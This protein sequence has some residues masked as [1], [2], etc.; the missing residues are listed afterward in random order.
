[1]LNPIHLRTL[2]AVVRTGSFAAAAKELGYT[3]SAI[4]QQIASLEHDVGLP[5]FERRARSVDPTPAAAFLTDR[6]VEVLALLDDLQNAVG[7][8]AGGEL[9]RL[10]IGS[11]PTASEHLLPDAIAQLSQRLPQVSIELE[12]AEPDQLVPLVA[13]R[14]LD[15]A[16]VYEYDLV[17]RAWP[18]NLR[19]TTLLSEELVVLLPR[20]G[21][22]LEVGELAELAGETWISTA[23]GTAGSEC[24]VR[25]C[26]AEG[27]VPRV[28]F[29]TNDYDV[30]RRFVGAGLGV[31]LVPR[32]GAVE[33]E[34]TR[35]VR[36]RRPAVQRHIIAVQRRVGA[37]PLATKALEVLLQVAQDRG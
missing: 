18:R 14:R 32:L 27:F 8:L 3:S 17:P 12:E 15:I 28:D 6:A 7:E 10:R 24:L 16:V 11:F 5:L 21:R 20:H 1:M 22:E 4:S 9:G 36:V 13:D 29:R 35:V 25:M 33:D 31:A 19:R 34:R 2:A 30:V 23:P 37:S 26:A